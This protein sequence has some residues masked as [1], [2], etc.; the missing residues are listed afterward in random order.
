MEDKFKL[1]T[2]KM[3]IEVLYTDEKERE[4]DR[5]RLWCTKHVRR[6]RDE[7]DTIHQ[8]SLKSPYHDIERAIN[9]YRSDN[10]DQI[11]GA[12][13]YKSQEYHSYLIIAFKAYYINAIFFSPEELLIIS[14]RFHL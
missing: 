7:M 9:N 10:S 2:L 13:W 1:L 11:G 6:V 8:D 5:E 3:S 12:K 14:F 4:K